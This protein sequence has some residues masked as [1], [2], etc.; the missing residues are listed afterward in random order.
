MFPYTGKYTESESDIQN[1]NF[2]YKID[3][4]YQ[5]TF[6]TLVFFGFFENRKFQQKKTFFMLYYVLCIN[7]IIHIL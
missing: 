7:S 4:E 1:Y 2:L 6:E 5:N 3:Q